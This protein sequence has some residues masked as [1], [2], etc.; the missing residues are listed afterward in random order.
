M[1]VEQWHA[2]KVGDVIIDNKCGGAPRVVLT[3]NR[4]SG[5]RGQ[6]GKTRTTITVPNLKSSGR[7]THIV[8]AEDEDGARFELVVE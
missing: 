7:T 3:L 6:R 8:N 1:T 5:K 4:V 2:L